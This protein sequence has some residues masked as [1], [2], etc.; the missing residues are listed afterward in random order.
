MGF[1]YKVTNNI[2]G[3][4]YVGQTKKTI[5]KRWCEHLNNREKHDFAFYRALR[6]YPEE[7]FEVEKLE[8]VPNEMLDDREMYWIKHYDS[9]DNGY[10][11]TLGGSGGKITDS[12]AIRADWKKGYSV[13]EIAERNDC[14]AGTVTSVLHQDESYTEL[15]SRKRAQRSRQR[16]V[17]MY[18]LEG[19]PVQIYDSIGDAAKDKGCRR[20]DIS[21]ACRR[22]HSAIG[23]CQWRYLED[24]PPGKYHDNS[25]KAVDQYTTDGKYVN[26]YDS[27]RAAAD[28]TSASVTGI[29]RACKTSGLLS[30]GYQW[31][32]SGDSPPEPCRSKHFRSVVKCDLNGNALEVY[33]SM[34]DAGRAEGVDVTGICDCCNGRQQTAGGYI[35]R[36]AE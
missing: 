20:N 26:T 13:L 35:W 22:S 2:N 11:S 19:R 32:N 31:R 1:I 5:H 34:A 27:V 36:Y 10:N 6:K 8:E 7:V 28:Q 21:Q 15:E 18:D 25:K 29:R 30:G 14:C 3:N 16:K 23:G 24:D 9:Y 4:V 33:D 12:D 17:A